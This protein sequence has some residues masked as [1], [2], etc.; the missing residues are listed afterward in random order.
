MAAPGTRTRLG[1]AAE[2]YWVA[3]Q[4]PHSGR[5][6][7]RSPRRRGGPAAVRNGARNCYRDL[8]A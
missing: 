7:S 4:R 1:W 3:G 5:F 6:E 8:V 2:R